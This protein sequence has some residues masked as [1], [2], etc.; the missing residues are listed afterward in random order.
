MTRQVQSKQVYD[1]LRKHSSAIVPR[2]ELP[3]KRL[4]MLMGCF[5]LLDEDGNGSVEENELGLAM[6]ALGFSKKD[7]RLAFKQGD[8]NG[9]GKL[10]FEDFV[11]LFTIAWAQ[12]E[13]REAFNDSFA[14]DM[15]DIVGSLAAVPGGSPRV[16]GRHSR[17]DG[18]ASTL[19]T[20]A[21]STVSGDTSSPRAHGAAAPSSSPPQPSEGVSGGDDDGE[22]VTTA[23]PFALV[24]NS[25]RITRLIDA[26]NPMLRDLKMAQELAQRRGPRA[27]AAAAA[28][29]MATE[30]NQ[31]GLRRS[32][33]RS[34]VAPQHLNEDG[35]GGSGGGFSPLKLPPIGQPQ[36][37]RGAKEGGVGYY[38]ATTTAHER[39]ADRD[40]FLDGSR[41]RSE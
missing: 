17:A 12:K 39:M 1:W 19:D 35:A 23:F 38:E 3:R 11:Q 26:C 41:R 4:Q 14:R 10:D 9:D 20:E 7:A 5:Q 29:T 28:V 34:T 15:D 37:K 18:G 21:A 16:L 13:T 27:A 36:L 33:R 25:H 30:E 40:R 8:R 6:E 24:A 2:K 22:R 31:P 32:R